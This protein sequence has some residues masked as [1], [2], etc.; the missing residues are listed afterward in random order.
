VT[1]HHPGPKRKLQ[2]GYRAP[3]QHR[4]A[5]CRQSYFCLLDVPGLCNVILFIACF[6]CTCARYARIRRSG[7]ILTPRLPLCQILFLSRPTLLS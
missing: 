5:M 4:R 2:A 7:I 3:S 6:L 1:G